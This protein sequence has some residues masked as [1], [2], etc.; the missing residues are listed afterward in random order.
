MLFFSN[1]PSVHSCLHVHLKDSF[2]LKKLLTFQQG[3]KIRTIWTERHNFCSFGT[4]V[5]MPCTS[6]TYVGIPTSSLDESQT[7]SVQRHDLLCKSKH[8]EV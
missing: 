1:I 6:C 5:M 3:I 7:F 4:A 2:L 8:W